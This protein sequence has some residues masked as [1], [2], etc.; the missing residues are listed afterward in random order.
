MIGGNAHDVYGIDVVLA[1]PV[2]K[3]GAVSST[4]KSGIGGGVFA[5][6]EVGLGR[7]DSL[8]HGR[9]VGLGYTVYGPGIN[10]IRT[11]RKVRA[12]IYMPILRG[13]DGVIILLQS[14]DF[15]GDFIASFGA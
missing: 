1:Q 7:P 9:A 10:K 8:M 3:Q 4:L 6:A 15:G 13:Y 2:S 14:R 12:R 5:L 11:L